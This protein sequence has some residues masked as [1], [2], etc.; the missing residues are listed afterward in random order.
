MKEGACG[1]SA[2]EWTD[3]DRRAGELEREREIKAMGE[4]EVILKIH[5]Y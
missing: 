4:M 2:R 3:Q 5:I 1:Q